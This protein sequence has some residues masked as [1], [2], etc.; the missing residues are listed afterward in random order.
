MR[1]SHGQRQRIALA[2]ALAGQSP[3]IIFDEAN[4]AIDS[5]S[6]ELIWRSIQSEG[7]ERLIIV[8]SHRL[9]SLKHAD[10]IL[11]LHEGTLV[12]C[13]RHEDLIHVPLYW[14]IFEQQLLP[15]ACLRKDTSVGSAAA[16]GARS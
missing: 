6:E 8:V 13:G 5:Q 3:I 14:D 2:R 16:A 9:A 15:E 11:L 7:R 4:A 10:L 1:L 12:A